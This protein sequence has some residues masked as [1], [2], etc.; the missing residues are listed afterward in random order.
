MF[1][2]EAQSGKV[3]YFT[4]DYRARSGWSQDWNLSLAGS[5]AKALD[6][7]ALWAATVCPALGLA[8]SLPFLSASG[9]S[10]G[11]LQPRALTYAIPQASNTPFLSIL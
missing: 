7:V 3:T 2:R 5:K 4:Q 1:E 10:E 9:L 6:S 11:L 8:H